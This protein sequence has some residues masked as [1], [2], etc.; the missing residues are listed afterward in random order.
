MG[1]RPG[2][3]LLVTDGF[4]PNPMD[5]NADNVYFE[6]GKFV[7]DAGGGLD[8]RGTISQ[9]GNPI[10]GLPAGST[11]QEPIYNASGGVFS[12]LH[13]YRP[14]AYGAALDGT[15]DDTTPITNMLT[16]MG[17][18][19]R[20]YAEFPNKVVA[21]K[22]MPL[23][24]RSVV[25][26][27]GAHLKLHSSATNSDDVVRTNNFDL[28]TGTNTTVS[29]G[30]VYGFELMNGFL[31]TPTDNTGRNTLAIYGVAYRLSNLFIIHRGVGAGIWTEYGS[32]TADWT[33][34][35]PNQYPAGKSMIFEDIGILDAVST[36]NVNSA[37]S[38]NDMALTT[39]SVSNT[40]NPTLTTRRPHFLNIGQPVT[41]MSV[42]GATGVNGA[43]VVASTPSPV[44][45]SI[46]TGSP[47][48]FTS[49][50]SGNIRYHVS[51]AWA[52]HGPSD[53]QATN[54]Y[55]FSS[56]HINGRR[57]LLCGKH[58]TG[59]GSSSGLDISNIHVYNNFDVAGDFLAGGVTVG[60]GGQF[61]GAYK[62]C[63]L[64]RNGGRF[65]YRGRIYG[66]QGGVTLL[67]IRDSNQ[68]SID[69]LLHQGGSGAAGATNFP[70]VYWENYNSGN[71]IARIMMQHDYNTNCIAAQG[72]APA[73]S[74]IQAF[75]NAFG[76]TSATV[77]AD[78]GTVIT[79]SGPWGFAALPASLSWVATSP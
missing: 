48:V 50:P 57:G 60:A 66:G 43:Q 63:L 46:A 31:E 21:V 12:I 24:A 1:V 41:V 53:G 52:H 38:S 30:A 44:Q 45:F 33:Q 58:L 70:N 25:D 47:G 18:A 65:T 54:I 78:F 59:I 3:R 5:P 49:A 16:D 42:A 6:N 51:A 71:H 14:Q 15:T 36:A 17:N 9:N 55:I 11:S 72:S 26:L 40:N 32:Q 73:Q 74:Y 13:V 37:A 29:G 62:C 34:N 77:N 4:S 68:N 20:G 56:T 22:N 76:L 19:G 10:S 28:H 27:N 8:V 79:A 2:R 7:I 75:M 23:F 39:V 61:E 69:A 67:S 35:Q 64:L